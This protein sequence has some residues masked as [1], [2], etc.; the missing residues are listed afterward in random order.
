[1]YLKFSQIW[2]YFSDTDV[3]EV[4]GWGAHPN[5]LA[6]HLCYVAS[7]GPDAGRTPCPWLIS[8][9]FWSNVRSNAQ[10]P[11]AKWFWCRMGWKR[12]CC[13]TAT[14]GEHH[15]FF[16]EEIGDFMKKCSVRGGSLCMWGPAFGSLALG[17]K[18]QG[19]CGYWCLESA[20][21]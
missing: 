9:P 21:L 8:A 19:G 17:A 6:T 13:G 10:S 3:Q 20:Q 14:P 2:S 18:I 16:L 11:S 15:I 12:N 4:W 7:A 1:M 5:K